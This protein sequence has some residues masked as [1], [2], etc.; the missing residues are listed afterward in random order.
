[1]PSVQHEDLNHDDLADSGSCGSPSED[2]P[3]VAERI[4]TPRSGVTLPPES[5]EPDSQF[6]FD[7]KAMFRRYHSSSQIENTSRRNGI[8]VMGTSEPSLLMTL[9]G[10]LVVRVVASIAPNY[11]IETD[12]DRLPPS[13]SKSGIIDSHMAYRKIID[14]EI[15]NLKF[16]LTKAQALADSMEYELK[17]KNTAYDM[18]HAQLTF[19]SEESLHSMNE[20]SQLE[21]VLGHLQDHTRNTAL[22]RMQ[23]EER[24]TELDETCNKLKFSNKRYRN[25]CRK[26][27]KE[28]GDLEQEL[29]GKA[30]ENQGLKSENDWLK[31]QLWP[32]KNGDAESELDDSDTNKEGAISGIRQF[33]SPP[34]QR[35][36]RRQTASFATMTSEENLEEEERSLPQ[37]E[38]GED[39]T[40]GYTSLTDWQLKSATESGIDIGSKHRKPHSRP[41]T[42]M[43]NL[44]LRHGVANMDD[45]S[46]RSTG[47]DTSS[48]RANSKSSSRYDKIDN[49]NSNGKATGKVR[50]NQNLGQLHHA[51]E[52]ISIPKKEKSE[53][54]K[55]ETA[56]NHWNLWGMFAGTGTK[57]DQNEERT[58]ELSDESLSSEYFVHGTAKPPPIESRRNVTTDQAKPGTVLVPKRLSQK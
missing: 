54:A 2:S 31:K 28:V 24:T 18:L 17:N 38:D 11:C 23:L 52:M 1:M 48:I 9:E 35:R 21:T 7:R 25:E 6:S 20:I 57:H 51:D 34:T 19:V 26:L 22:E 36:R 39:Q 14:K 37:K 45:Q 58:K 8:E 15:C 3:D 43:S 12:L 16:Q 49:N 5:A 50:D 10:P 41:N 42:F 40:T 13:P 32:E 33:L 27:K 53:A 46:Y 47:G 44:A 29:D 30:M 4:M 56:S 55:E